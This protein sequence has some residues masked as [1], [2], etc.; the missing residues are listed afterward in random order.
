MACRTGTGFSPEIETKTQAWM[1]KRQ[2]IV[3]RGL[4]SRLRLKHPS[5]PFNKPP[6]YGRTG[7]GFSPE[8]ETHHQ[9]KK[10]RQWRASHGDW[11]LA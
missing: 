8:I 5:S 4:A 9:M 10:W 7:T 2:E 11:L 1:M 6:M 3:A